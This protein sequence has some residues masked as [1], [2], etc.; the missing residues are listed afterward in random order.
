[1]VRQTGVVIFLTVG[2]RGSATIVISADLI[3][4]VMGVFRDEVL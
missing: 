4:A 1:M 2:K 3:S